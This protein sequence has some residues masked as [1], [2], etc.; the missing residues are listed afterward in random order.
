MQTGDNNF[1]AKFSAPRHYKVVERNVREIGYELLSK[2]Q[3]R[4]QPKNVL[5]NLETETNVCGFRDIK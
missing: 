2:F 1:Y 4:T 3:I 5:K